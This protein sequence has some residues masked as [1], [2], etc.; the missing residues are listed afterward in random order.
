M[1]K[2]QMKN[3]SFPSFFKEGWLRRQFGIIALFTGGDGVV[4]AESKRYFHHL[5]QIHGIK[6]LTRISDWFTW[7][8]V[9][10]L[11]RRRIFSLANDSYVI[12]IDL[13]AFR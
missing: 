9:L 5:P 13:S 12:K 7:I 10:L 4:E 6:K 8:W 3:E 11:T 2:T 1:L